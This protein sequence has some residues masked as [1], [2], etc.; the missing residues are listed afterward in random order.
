VFVLQLS[1]LC[2]SG[3][4]TESSLNSMQYPKLSLFGTLAIVADFLSV[5]QGDACTLGAGM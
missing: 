2:V 1:K 3:Q 4:R 5:S